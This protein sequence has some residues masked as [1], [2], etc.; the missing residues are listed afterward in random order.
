[1]SSDDLER[2]IN[3]RLDAIIENQAKFDEQMSKMQEAVA[4]LIQVARLNT[5]QIEAL[6]QQGKEQDRRI[7]EIAAGLKEQRE[8]VDA[9]RE[10][11]DALIRIVEGHISNHP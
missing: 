7:D 5:E 6:V 3:N 4:G 2:R 9:L 11:V 1:M 10:T 8:T